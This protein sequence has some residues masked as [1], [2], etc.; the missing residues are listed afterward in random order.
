MSARTYN[1]FGDDTIILSLDVNRSLVGL[2]LCA[3][4]Q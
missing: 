4:T 1:D 3:M 2:L